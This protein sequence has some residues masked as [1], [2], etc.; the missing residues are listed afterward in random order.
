M[1]RNYRTAR[2]LDDHPSRICGQP[3][4]SPQIAITPVPQRDPRAAWA[5]DDR[6]P[7]ARV[8]RIRGRGAPHRRPAHPG[9]RPR[10]GPGRRPARHLARS[11]RDRRSPRPGT[12]GA[13]PRPASPPPST[14]SPTRSTPSRPTSPRPTATQRPISR[15]SPGGC[16]DLLL[17][18]RPRARR[19]RRRR[20]HRRRGP[21]HRGRR[22]PPLARP[23]PPR[24]LGR[25]RR[26]RPPRRARGLDPVV[27][28]DARRPRPHAPRRTHRRSQLPERSRGEARRTRA[29]NRRPG[30]RASEVA[31]LQPLVLPQP[32][33]T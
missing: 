5:H 13:T 9:P 16:H 15:C 20:A 8:P 17:H 4:S 21:P 6:V 26:R 14:A 23:P 32:S 18:L 22:R 29:G 7:E 1:F 27:R 10:L 19:G 24:D 2:P 28:R 11:S 3:A 31:Q 25:H 12:T 30:S 33:Q